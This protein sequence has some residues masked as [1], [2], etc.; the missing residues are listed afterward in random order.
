MDSVAPCHTDEEEQEEHR[1]ARRWDSKDIAA[2]HSSN[3][4]V[5][6]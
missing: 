3:E 1:K 6:E 2:V 4:G 5:E